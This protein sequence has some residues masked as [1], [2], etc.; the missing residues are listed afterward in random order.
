MKKHDISRFYPPGYDYGKWNCFAI[1]TLV[2]LAIANLIRYGNRFGR[3]YNSLN[4]NINHT[5]LIDTSIKME[6]FRTIVQGSTA[7]FWFL[8]AY[9]VL[10]A[11]AIRSYFTRY[12]NSIYIMKRLSS[13]RELTIRCIAA[14][15]ALAAAGLLL[16]IL[17]I[18]IFRVH[19]QASVPA[20]CLPPDNA[21][22]LMDIIRA[23]I[24]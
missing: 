6:H 10:W 15:L 7:A 18:L 12:S 11:L 5:Y 13:S 1:L 16:S 14:P 22:M 4:W 3:A 20:G 17:M 19:Y 24:L 21:F 8:L 9:C 23:F 2:A